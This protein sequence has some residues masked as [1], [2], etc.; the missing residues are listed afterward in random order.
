MRLNDI[1]LTESEL[2]IEMQEQELKAAENVLKPQFDKLMGM[3]FIFRDHIF[4]HTTKADGRETMVT[5]EDVVTTLMKLISNPKYNARMKGRRSEGIEYNAVVTNRETGL[6]MAFA[7]DYT[8][9]PKRNLFK[10]T[11]IMKK[12][13]FKHQQHKDRDRFYV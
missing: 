6:N 7:I 1:L 8:S 2:L 5:K 10:V 11:T 12:R 13:N 9:R 3:N 4:D